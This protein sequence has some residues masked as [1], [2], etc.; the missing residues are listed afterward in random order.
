MHTD[1]LGGIITHR[2]TTACR[3]RRGLAFGT[4]GDGRS[5][6]AP[7][8]GRYRTREGRERRVADASRSD[9]D[10]EVRSCRCRSLLL[11]LERTAF[12][13][14][15]LDGGSTPKQPGDRLRNSTGQRDLQ[16]GTQSDSESGR[17]ST[18]R[19]ATGDRSASDFRRRVRRSETQEEEALKWPV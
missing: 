2:R 3:R 9:T 13:N 1:S 10:Y 8:A 5:P 14:P 6:A 7:D 11:S 15:N 16:T 12:P 19:S 4:P 18:H 17:G